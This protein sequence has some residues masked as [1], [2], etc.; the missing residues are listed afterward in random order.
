MHKRAA[1]R[2]FVMAA[3]VIR[4]ELGRMALSWG[5]AAREMHTIGARIGY[6]NVL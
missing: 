6:K 3:A 5:A 1:R 4:S 2:N